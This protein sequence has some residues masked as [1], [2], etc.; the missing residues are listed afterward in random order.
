MID[1]ILLSNLRQILPLLNRVMDK[2]GRVVDGDRSRVA[3]VGDGQHSAR[4]DQIGQGNVVGGANVTNR[5]AIAAGQMRQPFSLLHHML[6]RN[7]WG[8]G[9]NGRLPP[10]PCR[11]SIASGA[12]GFS[13]RHI[14][15][16]TGCISAC[17][18]A[19]IRHTTACIR[20]A[21]IRHAANSITCGRVAICAAGRSGL[22]FACGWRHA[23]FFG[24][25]SH[26]T[27]LA[28]A[29]VNGRFSP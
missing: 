17:I 13:S 5:C 3:W 24:R 20:I 29:R 12:G 22:A 27:A 10:R 4:V 9:G 28:R 8:H 7:A 6:R 26:C 19:C 2:A 16:T 25:R 18:S 14:A 15:T 23:A 21:R 11:R 1:A